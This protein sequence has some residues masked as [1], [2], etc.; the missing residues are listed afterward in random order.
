MADYKTFS[1][2]GVNNPKELDIQKL[3]SALE[4]R[5]KRLELK[6]KK[7]SYFRLSL[8]LLGVVD[9]CIYF[10]LITN[11]ILLAFLALLIITFSITTNF[12][13]KIDIA[14]DRTKLWKEIKS[15]H[16]AR[17]RLDWKNIPVTGY[18]GELMEPA[19][20][21]LNITGLN[22]LH[23]LIN[24]AV[25]I[26][27]KDILRKY[28]FDKEPRLEDILRRQQLVKELLPF[29]RF[30]D[31]I[32]LIALFPSKK[33]LDGS[34]IFN[35]LDSEAV[36]GR[37]KKYLTGLGI[38]APVNIILFLLSYFTGIFPY[39]IFSLFI[40]STLYYFG[41]RQ[42]NKTFFEFEF[43]KDELGKFSSVFEFIEKYSF[44]ENSSIKKFCECY[45]SVEMSPAVLFK[46]I[47]LAFYVLSLRKGNPFIWLILQI[48]FPIDFYYSN[49]L[50]Y[51][52]KIIRSHFSVW[53][54]TFYKLEAINSLANFAWLNP[55]YSF[56]EIE[57]V[58]EPVLKASHLG[59]P[60]IKYD[61]KICNDFVIDAAGE[62]NL[63]TGSNMSGKS[64]FLRTLGINICLAYAGAPVNADN[65]KC[66]LLRIFTCIR[67]SDS[68][69]DGISY[70]YAE[71]KR[72][73]SLLEEAKK[74]DPRPLFF[75]IDEIFRGTNNIERLKGSAAYI[76]TLS[77]L[78]A[79]GALATHDLE[80][81]KL[82][83][84]IEGLINYHFKENINGGRM[85]FDYKIQPG[86]C[87]TTNALKIMA[88][89]GL[90]T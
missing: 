57:E 78:N 52:R 34:V 83:T 84:E 20:S 11:V 29:Q 64:T 70:F 14:A 12:H 15:V 47:S 4:N 59:H 18:E 73:K 49:K 60:L 80:L 66:S 58:K 72:L 61:K 25:T 75:L 55:G 35:W 9:F 45:T 81:V 32:Q 79:T 54:N 30:R 48:L 8:F 10:F 68:V 2:E 21:D 38:L 31:K 50:L 90:P 24:T 22:S 26:Q 6:S 77:G 27:G 39:W 51:Y 76:K 7:Y 74:S 56:P 1:K 40:Y 16:L 37:D 65:L 85:T 44:P 41:N 36:E 46:K 62:I 3:I 69:I 89:E 43:L 86:P 19:E 28:L 53:L 17:I 33:E 42:K 71:V 87:P 23:Q 5:I 63:I 13:N 67:V 82:E 88:L